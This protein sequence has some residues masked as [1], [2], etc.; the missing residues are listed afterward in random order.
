MSCGHVGL[1]ASRLRLSEIALR[2]FTFA[3]AAS[4]CCYQVLAIAACTRDAGSDVTDRASRT[5]GDESLRSISGDYVA[6]LRRSAGR[7]TRPQHLAT[8]AAF[9]RL[10]LTMSFA[11][12]QWSHVGGYLALQVGEPVYDEV[13][14]S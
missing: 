3:D 7:P 9:R 12:R 8:L 6:R 10:P 5:R 4:R 2:S 1:S 11:R 14:H 13:P